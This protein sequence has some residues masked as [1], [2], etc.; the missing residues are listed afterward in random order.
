M[1]SVR[2]L[3]CLLLLVELDDTSLQYEM[4]ESELDST[5]LFLFNLLEDAVLLDLSHA[6]LPLHILECLVLGEDA[7]LLDEMSES[8]LESTSLLLFDLLEEAALLDWSLALFCLLFLECLVFVLFC[9]L[10]LECLLSNFIIEN[11]LRGESFQLCL[12]QHRC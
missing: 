6:L 3:D 7:S 10:F 11:V 2:L 8:E 4:P 12:V 9:L 5:S 1:K